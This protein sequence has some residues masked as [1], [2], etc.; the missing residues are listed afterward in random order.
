MRRHLTMYVAG[1]PAAQPRPRMVRATG[2]VYTPTT[3][4]AWKRAVRE[5]WTE[6]GTESFAGPLAVHLMISMPRP[7]SHLT[8]MGLVTKAAPRHHVSRPDIDNLSKSIL[9]A[10]TD[11]GAFKDDSLIV[12][13]RASKTWAVAE[14]GC[15][16]HLAEVF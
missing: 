5:A 2:R 6:A 13:L 11:I 15:W 10:L 16:I 4:D 8:R 9:D 7:K 14:P 3:A 1:V 12:T